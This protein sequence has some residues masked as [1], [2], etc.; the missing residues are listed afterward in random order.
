MATKTFF[1]EST[2]ANYGED[3]FNYLHK[4][5]LDEGV[6]NTEGSDWEDWVANGDLLVSQN[7]LGADMSVDIAVGWA[8]VETTRSA[9]TFKVFVQNIAVANVAVTA[10]STGSNRVDAVILRVDRDGESNALMNNIATFE[11]VVGSG[12]AALSDNDIQTA[13]GD[14]DDF[15]RLADITV[16]D[17]TPNIKNADIADTRVRATTND[18]VTYNPEV[19]WFGGITADPATANLSEGMMWYNTTDNRFRYYDGVSIIDVDETNL[20]TSD[21][22]AALAGTG[23]APSAANAYITEQDVNY[24]EMAAFF[25]A[26]DIS[27]AEAETLTDGSDADALHT[28]E[29]FMGLGGATAVKSYSKF[30]FENSSTYWTAS[31]ATAVFDG[32]RFQY[33]SASSDADWRI[34]TTNGL[35]FHWEGSTLSGTYLQFANTKKIIVEFE[36]RVRATGAEQQ[37]AG[38]LNVYAPVAD[39]DDITADAACF[40]IDVTGAL[41]AHTSDAGVGGNETAIAGVTVTDTNTYRIEFDPGVDVKFYVNG[42][43]KATHTEGVEEIPDG[44]NNIK[45]GYGGSGNTSNNTA[46]AVS[47]LLIAIEK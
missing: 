45:F 27:G 32:G 33:G 16:P 2:L 28:H 43:L 22:K 42:V 17:S 29:F 19:I 44:T 34:L 5:L 30:I 15:I 10:N 47:K 37:G 12:V 35:S 38:L 40:T 9:V 39:F 26:T 18:S 41:Y 14:D 8:V 6:L 31:N 25:T 3:E 46:Q 36:W 11:V 1:L 13:L 23:G 4:F 24:V 20:P 21:E 7:A